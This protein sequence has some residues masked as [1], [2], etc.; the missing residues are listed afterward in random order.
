MVVASDLLVMT[1]EYLVV[2]NDHFVL[3][4]E[5]LIVTNDD[6]VGLSALGSNVLVGTRESLVGRC[7][8]LVVAGY[9]LVRKC[10]FLFWY[11]LVFALLVVD[12]R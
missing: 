2:T 5:Y 3:T 10:A 4:C 11:C 6:C 1:S 9:Y 12:P 7:D 8:S